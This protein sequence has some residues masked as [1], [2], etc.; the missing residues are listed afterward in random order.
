MGGWLLELSAVGISKP[1]SNDSDP[2]S[3]AAANHRQNV[4]W[5]QHVSLMV[6]VLI[7]GVVLGA[8]AAGSEPSPGHRARTAG[9]GAL[10]A[11]LVIFAVGAYDY[12]RNFQIPAW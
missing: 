6:F 9:L 8:W 3:M 1:A 11:T 7:G 2:V 10:L 5:A 12:L 4:L